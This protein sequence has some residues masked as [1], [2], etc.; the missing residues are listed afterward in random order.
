MNKIGIFLLR[1]NG[2]FAFLILEVF[3]F[4]IFF[5]QNNNP[6]K[7]AFLSSAN[8]MVGNVYDYTNRWMRYWNLSALNDSLAKEN[9][10]LKMRLPGSQFSNLTDSANIRDEE[11]EQR[12]RFT[13]AIVINNSVNRRNNYITLNR[14]TKHGVKM[15]SAVLNGTGEGVAGIVV[16]VSGHFS[17]AMSVLHE[18]AR[19]SAKIKRNGYFGVA[20]WN[21]K[22]PARLT[23]EAIPKHA[24]IIKGDTIITSGYSTIFPEGIM[25]GTIDSFSYEPGTNFYNIQLGLSVDI[26]SLQYVYI[27]DDLMKDELKTLEEK[28]RK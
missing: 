26:N 25:I 28:K 6:E 21:G 22:D 13:E 8:R 17:T 9:A 27:V 20:T 18:E 12:Y 3:S 14:G 2:L 7:T 23:L 11:Y 10:R 16:A 5:S 24:K 19:I 15:H 1:F 4:Y